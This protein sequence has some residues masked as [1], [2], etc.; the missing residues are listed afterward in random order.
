VYSCVSPVGTTPVFDNDTTNNA[1]GGGSISSVVDLT[2]S[3]GTYD[4]W[5]PAGEIAWL[6]ASTSPP[7]NFPKGAAGTLTSK[8]Y[9]QLYAQGTIFIDGS[10]TVDATPVRVTGNAA[11]YVSG[12]FLVKN[13]IFCAILT[14]NNK[15]CDWSA[16]EQSSNP[17]I[18]LVAA[19]GNGSAGGA[20]SQVP[21]GDSI[22]IKGS[23]A[24]GA[25]Y[26]TN[27]V[28]VDTTSKFQGP[29]V[30]LT[31]I[32]SQTGG[33]PFPVFLTVPFGTPGNAIAR[34]SVSQVFNY[35]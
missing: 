32:I 4:C 13:A 7:A 8:A 6:P 21:N 22:E 15:D 9:G 33:S 30:A 25:L 26:G 16:W 23:S 35:R 27:A 2:P 29:M 12:T 28:E 1:T 31:D 3:T 19:N 20:Q 17:D 11:L 5:T 10:A 24:Q 18:F 34:Y 14:S